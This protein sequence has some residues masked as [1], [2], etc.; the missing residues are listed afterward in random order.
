MKSSSTK[1]AELRV[2][3]RAGASSEVVSRLTC[4][5][6]PGDSKLGSADC[7]YRQFLRAQ[8]SHRD[9]VQDGSEMGKG[10][11]RRVNRPYQ[12]PVKIHPWQQQCLRHLPAQSSPLS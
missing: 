11:G 1:E 9:R 12:S 5:L 8:V 10:Q 7:G 3:A 4:F 6:T 2:T